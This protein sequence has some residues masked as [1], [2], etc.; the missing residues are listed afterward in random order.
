LQEEELIDIIE[1]ARE[2]DE[3]YGHYFDLVIINN[4][5]ERTYHELL[6]RINY[7]EREPQWVRLE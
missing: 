3:K 7:T 6:Q 5:I 2:M 4:D 1:K